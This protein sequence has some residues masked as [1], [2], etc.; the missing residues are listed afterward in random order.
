MALL[1]RV[2]DRLYWGARYV[3]RAEDTARIVRAYHELVVDLPVDVMLRWE[4][5]A[6][7]AG[8]VVAFEFARRRLTGE[9]AVLHFLVADRAN[10]GSI[11]SCVAAARENLRTT[12]R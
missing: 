8:N 10:P 3:E 7:I 5:L 6:A 11:A 2:A 12:A 1:A 4:P 9:L